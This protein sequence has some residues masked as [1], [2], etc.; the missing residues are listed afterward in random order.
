MN[1]VLSM[2]VF[3]MTRLGDL[4]DFGQLFKDFGNH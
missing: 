2:I 3:K 4:F 1:K